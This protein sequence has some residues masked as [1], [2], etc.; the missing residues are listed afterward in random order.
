MRIWR[1]CGL[2]NQFMRFLP[3][4]LAAFFLVQTAAVWA[5]PMTEGRVRHFEREAVRAF[6]QIVSACIPDAL[7]QEQMTFELRDTVISG[8]QVAWGSL[9]CTG[10]AADTREA[11]AQGRGDF[12]ALRT[13]TGLS[14]QGKF[15]Q[16]A[17]QE[18]INRELA[19]QSDAKAFVTEADITLGLNQVFVTG[20]VFLNKIPGNVL[21]FL[22]PDAA[23]FAAAIT[24]SAQGSGLYLDI[25]TGTVNGQPITPELRQQVL[26]WLNPLWDNAGLPY[27]AGLASI[28]ITPEEVSVAGWLF[29][30]D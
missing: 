28:E 12:Q 13:I 24:V 29:S 20:K 2:G 6:R 23:P 3:L 16:A 17:L 15:R 5:L 8:L 19:R 26:S 18:L 22:S 11:F 7:S 14:G 21:G 27:P 9:R 4:A 30:P 10:L 25:I 1:I